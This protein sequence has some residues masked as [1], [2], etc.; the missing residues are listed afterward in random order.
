MKSFTFSYTPYYWLTVSS[1]AVL[2]F[3]SGLFVSSFWFSD[4]WEDLFKGN[5]EF[6]AECDPGLTEAQ[7]ITIENR[8]S[9]IEGIQNLRFV[10]ATE[11]LKIMKTELKELALPD[12]MDNPFRG[13]FR[14][15]LDA[16]R[17]DTA[18]AKLLERDLTKV[19]GISAFYYPED[20]YGAVRSRLKS[21]SLVTGAIGGIL[22]LLILVMIHHQIRMYIMQHRYHIRTM[23]LV[24][25]TR[26]YIRRPFIIEV[27]KMSSFSILV[28]GIAYFSVLLWIGHVVGQS[29]F[30]SSLDMVVLGMLFIIAL[31]ILMSFSAA[32]AAIQRY[33]ESTD[34]RDFI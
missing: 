12:S 23:S 31:G 29:L 13:S 16:E 3:L 32:W 21:I 17:V 14:F 5:I 10:S 4:R 19:D 15:T 9:K 20:L 1:L 33:L 30:A 34:A 26:G 8:L 2:L 24:G 7:L 22:L 28:A 18:Y 6:L 25:A 27:L 11:A